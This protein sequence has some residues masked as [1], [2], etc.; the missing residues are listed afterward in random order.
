[1]AQRDTDDSITVHC[2]RCGKLLI[3]R[4]ED[5]KDKRTIDCD[6]CENKRP[7]EN[8]LPI[9]RA[10]SVSASANAGSGMAWRP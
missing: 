5:I 1:M 10:S 8:T 4:L 7:V 3:V 9:I 6:A 2:G